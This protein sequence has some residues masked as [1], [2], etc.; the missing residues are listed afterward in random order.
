MSSR[1]KTRVPAEIGEAE[2]HCHKSN[3][4]LWLNK[5]RDK[6]DALMFQQAHNWK[7]QTVPEEVKRKLS[8]NSKA[9]D[10]K[11]ERSWVMLVDVET[12]KK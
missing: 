7:D 10:G 6:G 4:N 12:K 1:E 5:V 8:E 9:I 11:K 2:D 3:K